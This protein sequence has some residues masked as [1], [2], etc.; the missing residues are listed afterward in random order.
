LAE[1]GARDPLEL[2]LPAR[3]RR[4]RRRDLRDTARRRPPASALPRRGPARAV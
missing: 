1:R 3:R 4:N 2:P